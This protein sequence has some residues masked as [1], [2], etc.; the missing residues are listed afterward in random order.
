MPMVRV[1]KFPQTSLSEIYQMVKLRFAFCSADNEQCHPFV[2]CRDFLHDAVRTQHTGTKTSIY[3]FVFEKGKN[4][5]ID[6]ELMRMLM[7]FKSPPAGMDVEQGMKNAVALVRLYEKHLKWKRSILRQVDPQDMGN[8]WLVVGSGQWMGSPFLVSMYS[9]LL[10][11]GYNGLVAK[12]MDELP[13]LYKARAKS[14]GSNDN[15]SR[16]I[17]NCAGKM[18]FFAKNRKKLLDMKDGVDRLYF[19]IK[20]TSTFHNN[21]GIHSLCSFITPNSGLNTKFKEMLAKGA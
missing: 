9:F 12:N 20:D 18:A 8:T 5:P 6:F 19:D 2:F 10:R 16:Y 3:S 21:C 4:P 14:Q 11:L 1:K 15:D 7:D 17:Q 13:E